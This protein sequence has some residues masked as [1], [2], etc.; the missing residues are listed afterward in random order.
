MLHFDVPSSIKEARMLEAR[1]GL[2]F[3]RFGVRINRERLALFYWSGV[4]T[5]VGR[6]RVDQSG[7][8]DDL[9]SGAT[10]LCYG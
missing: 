7:K 9:L 3:A 10:L 4:A 5:F 2:V 8:P 1:S 6:N